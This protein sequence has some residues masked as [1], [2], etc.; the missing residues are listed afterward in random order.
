MND[1]QLEMNTV[2]FEQQFRDVGFGR[3]VIYTE[4]TTIDENNVVEE[5]NKALGYHEV[6]VS[7]INYLD[8]YYR[9]D[10]PILNREKKV[11]PEINNKIVENHALEIVDS[12][13][14][15]LFGEPIQYV[16]SD[17][18]DEAKARAIE[19]LNKYMKSEDKAALDIER[20]R[21]A[22]IAGTS[23]FFVGEENRMPKIFD[24]APY[25]IT[26]E[27]P[28]KT[29][30]VY[31]ADDKTPAFSCQ[32]RR[33]I[34]GNIYNVY[35][36]SKFYLI[37]NSEIIA[38]ADNGNDMIPVIEYPNNERRLSDIEI[39]ISITDAINGMQSDRMN[40]V[41]QFVQAFILFKNCKIDKETFEALAFAGALSIKDTAD[42]KV[43]DAKLMTSELSQTGTQVSNSLL[44]IQGMPSRNE[45]SGST[46]GQA[47]ALRNG[48]YAE[49]KRAELRILIF[50]KS[51]R[52]LLRVVL[53]KLRIKIQGFS[54]SISDI[55]IRPV[56]SKLENML[57]KA[58]VLQILHN[59]GVDDS[60]ALKT[61]NLFS[62]VQ[63]VISKSSE[64]MNDEFY[65]KIKE[66][67]VTDNNAD[68]RPTE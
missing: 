53:N 50:Q 49:E 45:A 52:M 7:A 25:Y 35:T 19:L 62:D 63:D 34:N 58:E 48:Y 41:E 67:E 59:I 24:E 38:I 4:E 12:K 66:S 14:A 29:F 33:D 56:R 65:A 32:I 60:V 6:N 13:V 1:I 40:A 3:L 64:R 15:D 16:L 22:S 68:V 44:V 18:E 46:T 10:Q 11:R 30:V 5:L 23:Y 9:G 54:L 55:D 17:N 36:P 27:N 37:Q 21:W 39:T 57:V 51:E 26:C 2:L 28:T 43:A 61:V 47:E 8:R 42:G 31:Y 20:A